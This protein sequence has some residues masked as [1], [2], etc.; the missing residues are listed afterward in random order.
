[1]L[2]H[3]FN[4]KDDLCIFLADRN[5]ELAEVQKDDAWLAKLGYFAGIFSEMNKLNK[6]MQGMS[7][8]FI[9]QHERNKNIGIQKKTTTLESLCL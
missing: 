9:A 7:I 1:M 3:I 2:I 6:T 4:L 5:P 8:N